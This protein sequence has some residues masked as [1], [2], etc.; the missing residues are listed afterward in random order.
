MAAQ[1]AVEAGQAAH[2]EDLPY[3]VPLFAHQPAAG[4]IELHLAAGVRAV[5]ELIQ[6]AVITSNGALLP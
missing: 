6:M 2:F 4:V 1:R 3:A 5:A